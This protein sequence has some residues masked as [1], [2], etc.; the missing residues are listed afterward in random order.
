MRESKPKTR[1][2]THYY[3]NAS[4][5]I[6]RKFKRRL[7]VRPICSSVVYKDGWYTVYLTFEKYG[8]AHC[9]VPDIGEWYKIADTADKFFANFIRRSMAQGKKKVDRNRKA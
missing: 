7:F 2:L 3:K 9:R 4:I 5:E 1:E 8:E 6:K